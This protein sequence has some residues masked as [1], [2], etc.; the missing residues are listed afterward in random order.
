MTAA[1]RRLRQLARRLLRQRKM[2][3][4]KIVENTI[5]S[6]HLNALE[7]GSKSDIFSK[8]PIIIFFS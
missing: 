5:D 1:H 6:V 4:S 8:L 2:A 7:L 3:G